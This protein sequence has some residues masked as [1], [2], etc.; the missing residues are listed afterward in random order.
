MK[1]LSILIFFQTL[2]LQVFAYRYMDT[3]KYFVKKRPIFKDLDELLA[4]IR[5]EEKSKRKR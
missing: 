3:E 4:V 2:L 1:N 5:K